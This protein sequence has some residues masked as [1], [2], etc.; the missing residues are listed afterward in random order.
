MAPRL[1]ETTVHPRPGLTVIELRGEID[2]F[3]EEGLG[4]AYVSAPHADPV[5]L[6]FGGV[7]YINSTGIALIIGVM[8]RANADGCRL[9][10]CRLSPHYREIF[11]ITRLDDFIPVFPDEAGALAALPHAA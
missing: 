11:R 6:D 2:S 7:S 3:A 4:A 10:A 1:L 5:L 9:L 8:K